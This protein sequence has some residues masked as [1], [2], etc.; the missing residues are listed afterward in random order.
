MRNRFALD[1]ETECGVG[2]CRDSQC[3][4]ALIPHLAR[5]TIIG[6]WSPEESHIFRTPAALGTF[7]DSRP[8]YELLGQN[9]KFD[10]RMLHFHGLS[11]PSARWADD[12]QLMAYVCLDKVPQEYLSWYAVERKK[13]NDVL[14]KG[15]GHRPGSA[16]SLKVLA[17]Y[18]LQVEPFWENPED[19]NDPTYC[20]RDCEYSYRLCDFFGA[21]LAG[22]GTGEFYRTRQLVWARRLLESELEGIAVDVGGLSEAER[23]SRMASDK[24]RAE[25]NQQ[26]GTAFAAYKDQQE[27]DIKRRYQILKNRALDKTCKAHPSKD[28]R[29]LDEKLHG[30]ETRYGALRDAALD[31]VEPIN[32]DSPKQLTWLLRD[33]F[34]LDIKDFDDE[35]STGKAV[36]N[37]LI[38]EGRTDLQ[39]FSDY[40]MHGKRLTSFFPT[41]RELLREGRLHTSFN[42]TGTRTGR[43]SSSGPNLQQ[44]PPDLRTLF[45]APPGYELAVFDESAIEPRLICYYAECKTL[46]DLLATGADFHGFNTKIF[47]GLDCDVADVK[48]LYPQ[49]R[50]MGKE[51][52]LAL[53]YGAGAN[54]IRQCAAKYG[55]QWSLEECKRKYYAFKREYES[56]FRFKQELDEWVRENPVKNLFGRKHWFADPEDIYMK[57]FNTLIQGTAS[58]L[59]QDA[60]HQAALEF[61]ARGIDAKPLLLVHDELVI[62]IPTGC[63]EAVEIIKDKMTGYL[64]QTA[65]GV[66][67]LD[68]EGKVSP[69]WAK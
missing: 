12:S 26:W 37:R 34:G 39:V 29:P 69:C 52:G 36:I 5:I 10:L 18:F 27:Q 67:R 65:H 54:R 62:R 21:R 32:L 16:L 28:G 38:S 57:N 50:R 13:R 44:V 43:I 47:F 41:Y 30:V 7:L 11:I 22:Q 19:H 68:V 1:L 4:H 46:Y 63:I 58:D 61:E 49:E 40:R 42:P 6:V 66:I 3:K 23:Q 64:L 45:V 33:H 8:D 51:A 48:K 15:H 20:L 53:F 2:G 59:V 25:L 55:F 17:P 24:L 14:T 35:E 9:L 60:G 56:V 31:K